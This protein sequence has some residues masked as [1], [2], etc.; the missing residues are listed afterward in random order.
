M[1]RWWKQ[2]LLWTAAASLAFTTY[3][4]GQPAGPQPG[5]YGIGPGHDFPAPEASLEADRANQDLRAQRLH[6]WNVFAGL[7]EPTPDGKYARWETWYSEDEA[8][9]DGAAPQAL[10][11]HRIQRRFKVPRQFAN[12]PG[13]AP[14]AAGSGLLSFVLFNYETY[15]HIRDNGLYR[16]VMFDG[17]AQSGPPDRH[18][19]D[20][21]TIPDFP[22]EAMSLKVVWWPVAKDKIT[23]MPIWDGDPNPGIG[24]GKS[25]TTWPRAVAIAPTGTPAPNATADVTLFGKPHQASHLVGLA[26]FHAITIDAALANQLNSDSS[27]SSLGMS[28]LGR[29][30]QVGDHVV[31]AGMHM[32]TKEIKD[33]VWATFWWHDQPNAGPFAADR[34]AS[35]AAP[36]GNYL[37]SASYDLDTPKASDGGPHVAFNPWLEARFTDG[38]HSNCMACHERSG[39]NGTPFLPITRG[40]P[41][42]TDPAFATGTVRADFL[43]SIPDNAH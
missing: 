15:R 13:A 41:S 32:T 17:F 23:G 10:G 29:A 24:A 19:A 33:W 14:Q 39:N 31:L 1:A 11:P 4:G 9:Q 25:F 12:A 6:V 43:W 35:L 18:F 38:V 16:R 30:F 5:Y 22:A 20:N 37:M 8:F 7:T 27:L 2:P 28:V 21:R 34:P 3:A 36:W 26:A 42:P 40:D